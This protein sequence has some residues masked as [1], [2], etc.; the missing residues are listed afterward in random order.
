MSRSWILAVLPALLAALPLRAEGPSELAAPFKLTIAREPLDVGG[1][2]YA[3][4]FV[5]DFDGDGTGDLLVGQFAEGKLRI[6]P[7]LGTDA[8]PKF[9][10]FTWFMDDR[11]EGRVP[12]G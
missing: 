12:T 10:G 8:D 4:P 6:Y 11:P 2:G 3:A 5:G 9:E 1:V 7:N